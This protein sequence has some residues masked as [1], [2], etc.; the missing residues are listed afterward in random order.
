V[1]ILI[2]GG[3]GYLGGHVRHR[4]EA[5]GLAVVTAGRSARPGPPPHHRADLAGDGPPAIA[6]LIGLVA[7][8]A[9]V[10]CTGT[11]T[12]GPEALA[13][14]NI[15]APWALVTAM[16]TLPARPRRPRLV[17]LGSAAEYG[18]GTPGV[19]VTESAP[20]RPAGLYGVTKLAGTRLTVLAR[21]AGLDAVVLRV[22]NPVGP[23]APAGS[24]AGRAVSQV[25]Q[26]LT[27]GT[28]IR[29][30]PLDAARDFV[31]AGDV[32]DAVLAAACRPALPPAVVNIGSG[33]ATPA[34]TLVR[35][36]LTISGCSAPVHEDAPGSVRSAAVPWQQAD[37]TC[38]REHLGWRPRRDLAASLSDLW[39]ASGGQEPG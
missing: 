17:H 33:R 27:S 34:R 4:A 6:A 16:L 8:D 7:P 11:V 1:R 24:L 22:F 36:L 9:V 30:G 5:A 19:P 29:L 31:D 12:G 2:L 35:Q 10:N 37:I 15:T 28:P 25:R 21:A 14:A 18:R 39:E 26:A 38:A 32:A 20:S 23:G 13:A 3:H